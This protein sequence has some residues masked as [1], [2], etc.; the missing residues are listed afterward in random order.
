MVSARLRHLEHAIAR[1]VGVANGAVSVVELDLYTRCNQVRFVY[2]RG[3]VVHAD[4][5]PLAARKAL[6]GPSCFRTL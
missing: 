4:R 3:V 2:A 6:E 1:E 5:F